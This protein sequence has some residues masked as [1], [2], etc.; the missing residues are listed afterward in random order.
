MASKM[1][2]SHHS[3]RIAPVTVYWFTVGPDWRTGRV[4]EVLG[5]SVSGRPVDPPATAAEVAEWSAA[6]D[7]YVAEVVAAAADLNRADARTARW[8][9]RPL[10]RHWARARFDV[11]IRSFVDRVTAATARYQPVR[12]AVDGRLAEQEAD[13]QRKAEAERKRQARVWHAAHGRFLAWR[14]KYE[15]ADRELPDGLTPRQLAAK[16]EDPTECPPE[17]VAAVGDVGSWWAGV[18]AASVNEHARATAV[19]QVFEAVTAIATALEEAGRPGIGWIDDE[20]SE[21][22]EGWLVL[23]SWPDLPGTERLSRP[24]D[25]PT[26]HLWRGRWYYDLHLPRRKVLTPGGRGEYELAGVTN[27]EPGDTHTWWTQSLWDFADDLFPDRVVYRQLYRYQADDVEIP[28]AHYADP[29]DFVPY[30]EAVAQ[31]AVEVFRALAPG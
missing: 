7:A 22:R 16:G 27:S 15:T 13:R 20:P 10:V 21:P 3:A 1:S 9:S 24:P 2:W 6:G 5:H 4:R 31:R 18:R 14:R 8:R 25:I 30:V 23:L 19:R 17:V 11:A 29:A 26:G 28:M 12:D